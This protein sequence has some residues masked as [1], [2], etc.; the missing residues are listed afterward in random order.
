M[1]SSR[2]AKAVA[3]ALSE[4]VQVGPEALSLLISLSEKLDPVEVVNKAIKEV[5]K[6][7]SITTLTQKELSKVLPVELLEFDQSNVVEPDIVGDLTIDLKI[8]KNIDVLPP[9][10]IDAFHGLLYNRYN[11]LLKILKE[12]PDSNQIIPILSLKADPNITQKIVGLVL[13]KSVRRNGVVLVIDDIGAKMTCIVTGD[14]LR[15]IASNI[16]LDQMIMLDVTMRDKG[17]SYVKNIYSP[18]VPEHIPVLAKSTIYAVFTSDLQ[19]GSKNFLQTEFR[20]FISWLSGKMG[21]VYVS[22]RIRYLVIAGDLVDGI[23]VYP[24]QDR[25]LEISDISSQYKYASDLLKMVPSNIE[26]II[27]PGNHDVSRQALPRPPIPRKYCEEL[28]EMHNVKMLGDP[29]FVSLHGVKVLISH[30]KSLDDILSTI[31]GLSFSR[32]TL[33]MKLLLNARHISP[34]YSRRTPLAPEFEDRLVIEDIPDI[35]H[36]GHIHT[37]DSEK[38]KGVL[39]LNSGTWQGQTPYQASRGILPISAIVPIVNLSTMEV[40]TRNFSMGFGLEF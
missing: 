36:S 5:R 34:S 6:T 14:E 12:R 24:G 3:G 27:I 23:G 11:K 30:G 18:D 40:M 26:I 22:K 2:I 35:F 17:V 31:P 32:P 13:D 33:G 39:L 20:K 10:G 29:C 21:D 8:S 1:L 7:H 16:L 15:N 9:S 28:Y 37:V 38:Y 4:G 25:D 19:I